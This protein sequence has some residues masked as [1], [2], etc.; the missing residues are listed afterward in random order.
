VARIGEDW[1][2]GSDPERLS[3]WIARLEAV[4]PAQVRVFAQRHWTP[5]RLRTVIA[6]PIDRVLGAAASPAGAL[7][8][9]ASTLDLDRPS[10]R[11]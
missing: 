5:E 11:R 9:E 1:S 3:R 7:R 10:L 8:L 6:G 4:S 2:L